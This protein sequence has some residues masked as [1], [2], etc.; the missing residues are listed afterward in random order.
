[1]NK[2]L[3]SY[4]LPEGLLDF[5]EITSIEKGESLTIHL[6]EKNITPVEHIGH[7][8]T[9]KGFYEEATI[10]DFPIRKKACFLKVKRR[11]WLNEDTGNYVARDWKLVA[12]GTRMTQ[13][14]A[15]FLKGSD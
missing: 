12:K 3:L 14:L 1:M 8:L 6:Q 2:E 10:Q 15:S 9:S 11:R 13:E 5:F 7:K 4:F